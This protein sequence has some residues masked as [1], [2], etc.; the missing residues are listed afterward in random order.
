MLFW[1]DWKKKALIESDYPLIIEIIKNFATIE[2][3]FKNSEGTVKRLQ[4]LMFGGK[5]ER[6]LLPADLKA[7]NTGEPAQGHGKRPAAAWVDQPLSV[8]FHSHENFK[9]GQLCPKC[10]QGKMYRFKPSVRVRVVATRA[11]DVEQH[12]IERLRC[13]ACGWLYTAQPSEDLRKNP[14]A[15]PAAMAMSALLRYQSGFPIYR[16]VDFLRAQGVYL[17]W[18]K[19]WGFILGVF[20]AGE[21]IFRT[22]WKLA[23]ESKLTQN[24]DT[25]MRVIDLMKSNRSKDKKERKAIQTTG[26]VMHLPDGHKIMLFKTGHENA[27]ENLEEIL[28]HRINPDPPMQMSDA[29]TANG[30]GAQKTIPGGCMDHF[31][32]E[33]YDLYDDWVA[34]CE[35]VLTHL[36]AVYQVDAQAKKKKLTPAQRLE[37]HQKESKP[38]IDAVY[39][40]MQTQQAQK[41]IEPNSNLG[42][43]IQYGINHWIKL[44]AFLRLE[45]MPISNIDV[46][47]LLKKAVIHRKNSLSYKT[48]KGAYVG[49]VLMSLI[50]T[51]KEARANAYNYL[52]SI[53]EYKQDVKEQP[54]QW[55]PWNYL[56]RLSQIK[57]APG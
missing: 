34:E 46:E 9:E 41:M 27:G 47:R 53:V 7:T 29:L 10:N 6:S 48:E 4:K 16:L 50:Q 2:A 30:A 28:S 40:W 54:E 17:T 25:R 57:L 38:H 23:A 12:E 42:K 19:I 52:T 18:S 49:D 22:L 21:L 43:A 35:L 55:L 3:Q 1:T 15:T 37:L 39:E 33:F 51:A 20:E 56:Q 11:L 14:D 44:T 13:S 45:G 5:T 24:D 8:C 26:L 31:R 36:R 32:R